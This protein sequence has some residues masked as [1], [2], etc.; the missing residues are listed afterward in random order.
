MIKLDQPYKVRDISL[1][2]HISGTTVLRNNGDTILHICAEFGQIK[3]FRYF[4]K[5]LQPNL[6]IKN[7]LEETPFIVAAR[8]GRIN[9]LKLHFNEFSN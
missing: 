7:K 3:L 1:Q 5:T 9:I 6:D 4:Y 2:K 8:E